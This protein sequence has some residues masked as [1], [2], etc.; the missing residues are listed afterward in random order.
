M[1]QPESSSI[2]DIILEITIILVLFTG[3]IFAINKVIR[4]HIKQTQQEVIK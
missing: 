3:T 1:K 4:S 2:L